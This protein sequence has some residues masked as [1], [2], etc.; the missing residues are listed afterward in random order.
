M[1]TFSM[2]G[3]RYVINMIKAR[4]TEAK[5][6]IVEILFD[7]LTSVISVPKFESVSVSVKF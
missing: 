6:R 2:I 5:I 7:S 3:Q 1:D 4:I